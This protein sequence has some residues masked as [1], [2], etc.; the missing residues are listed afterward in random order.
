MTINLKPGTGITSVDGATV[1]LTSLSADNENPTVIK[2][3][4]ASR[5]SYEALAAP[6]TVKANTPFIQVDLGGGTYYFRP[7]SAVV[8]EAS[9]TGLTVDVRKARQRIWAILCRTTAVTQSTPLTA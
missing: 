3:Y 1:S 6:Q 4:N 7:Q 8:L 2:T 5:N 9:V